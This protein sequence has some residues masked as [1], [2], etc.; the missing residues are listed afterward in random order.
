VEKLVEQRNLLVIDDEPAITALIKR[1]AQ[2]CGYNVVATSQSDDFRQH[3]RTMRTDVIGL[4][5]AMPTMDGIEILRHL[6]HERC[7]AQIL[8]I[9]GFDRRILETAL[10]LGEALGL[11]VV[12]TISKP[13]QIDK[14]R[15]LLVQ[16]GDPS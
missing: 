4:D 15:N 6:A 3:L 7:Q 9:S 1:I 16:L 5:L 14:L 13:L 11:N 8:I 10:R 12:G 2:G